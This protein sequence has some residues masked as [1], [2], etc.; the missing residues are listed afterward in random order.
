[1]EPGD[2]MDMGQTMEMTIGTSTNTMMQELRAREQPLHYGM[3]EATVANE[4]IPK[5][6]LV[7]RILLVLLP[8]PPIFI[9]CMKVRV[10]M[11]HHKRIIILDPQ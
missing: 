5:I 6:T 9:I 7:T 4:V 1:M 11:G 10:Q 2:I 3:G 8:C